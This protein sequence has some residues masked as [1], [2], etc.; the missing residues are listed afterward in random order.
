MV[1]YF[2]DSCNDSQPFLAGKSQSSSHSSSLL[3]GT[4]LIHNHSF[5][6]HIKVRSPKSQIYYLRSI[7]IFSLSIYITP[8]VVNI[9]NSTHWTKNQPPTP[10]PNLFFYLLSWWIRTKSTQMSKSE[11]WSHLDLF[12]LTPHI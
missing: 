3:S 2:N 11:I 6:N 4:E 12:P 5:N 7:L 1:K 9:S 10:L 8:S